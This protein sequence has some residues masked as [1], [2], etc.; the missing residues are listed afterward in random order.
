MPIPL[1]KPNQQL[2][3][4]QKEATALLKWPGV[5]IM[6][7]ATRLSEAGLGEDARILMKIAVSLQKA[8]SK[9]TGYA[10]E[11]KAG[12]INRSKLE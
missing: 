1:T 7:V 8:E 12:G 2:R 3:R 6:Q 4:D 9:L 10:E 5:D 11:M